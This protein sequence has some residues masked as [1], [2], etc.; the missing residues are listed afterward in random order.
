M[1]TQYIA[2]DGTAFNT[3]E[4]CQQYEN[5]NVLSN[6]DREWGEHIPLKERAHKV[7]A[8]WKVQSKTGLSDDY[9]ASIDRTTRA[10][11][12]REI[13]GE[14]EYG[15]VYM[16]DDAVDILLRYIEQLERGIENEQ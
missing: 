7:R 10:T 15:I 6:Y 13:A 11:N 5:E 9:L 16:R 4:E 2:D 14:L 8:Y 3:K 12:I 1:R